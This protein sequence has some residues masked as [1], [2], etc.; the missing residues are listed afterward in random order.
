MAWEQEA[1][2]KLSSDQQSG[3]SEGNSYQYFAQHFS[4]WCVPMNSEETNEFLQGKVS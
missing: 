3:F 4:S 1:V 2:A